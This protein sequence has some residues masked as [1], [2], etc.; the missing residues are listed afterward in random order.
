MKYIRKEDI[1]KVL[2]T[3][4]G[5]K[6]ILENQQ[7]I[8]NFMIKEKI[9]VCSIPGISK[10]LCFTLSKMKLTA[11]NPENSPNWANTLPDDSQI[12]WNRKHKEFYHLESHG[13]TNCDCSDWLSFFPEVIMT[14]DLEWLLDNMSNWR[15]A[16]RMN[17]LLKL[18]T[19]KYAEYISY[20]EL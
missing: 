20:I 13:V 16:L 17:L 9:S 12:V 8:H 18:S 14:E 7:A 4:G 15:F 19:G 6:L 10:K 3:F 1:E 2:N 11:S 5:K